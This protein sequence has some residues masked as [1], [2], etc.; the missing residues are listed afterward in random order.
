MTCKA[1]DALVCYACVRALC[2]CAEARRQA[3]YSVLLSCF[4]II[5]VTIIIAL[6]IGKGTSLSTCECLLSPTYV[7]TKKWLDILFNKWHV[8]CFGTGQLDQP[9]QQCESGVGLL[10]SIKVSESNLF[11]WW[12]LACQSPDPDQKRSSWLRDFFPDRWLG[13]MLQWPTLKIIL[14][15]YI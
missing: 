4:G 12:Q 15:R 14:D 6:V 9:P 8:I 7:S 5:V 11:C 2:V 3:R 10:I 13:S 1:L